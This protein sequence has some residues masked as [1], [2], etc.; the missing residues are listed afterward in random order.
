[1]DAGAFARLAEVIIRLV[2]QGAMAVAMVV[3]AWRLLCV[4]FSGGS[5]RAIRGVIVSLLIVGV[6]VAALG[7]LS[8][9]FGIV[10]GVG[11]S[12]WSVLGQ[13]VSGAM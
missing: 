6:T 1:M 2:V 12:I 13:A 8:Q 11:Q 10:V 4:L 7:N 9:T 3:I 5:E